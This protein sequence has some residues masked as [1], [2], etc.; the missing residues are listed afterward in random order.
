MGDGEGKKAGKQVIER[1]S[2][3][4]CGNIEKSEVFE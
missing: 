3:L 1:P 2:H 4:I